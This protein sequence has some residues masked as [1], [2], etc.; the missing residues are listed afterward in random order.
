MISNARIVFVI[1]LLALVPRVSTAQT[2]NLSWQMRPYCNQIAL[3]LVPSS[4]RGF[5]LSGTDDQCGALN[6]GSAVGQAS[7]N[8]EW[9]R[10]AQF[11]DRYGAGG[12]AGARVGH[13][14]SR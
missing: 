9:Q 6:K 13:R 8:L 10:H 1:S 5:S 11:L 4:A 2:L 12:Q 3:A 7:F 14:E